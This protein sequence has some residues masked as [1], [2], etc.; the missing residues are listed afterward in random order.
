MAVESVRALV[1]AYAPELASV[2]D[3][4]ID[5]RCDVAEALTSARVFGAYYT[6]ALAYLTAHLLTVDLRA[7]GGPTGGGG[8]SAGVGPVTAERVGDLSTSYGSIGWT[9]RS[10]A[11]AD[12]S[13]TS[14]GI[15]WLA[16][17]DSRAGVLPVV[18]I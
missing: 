5:L 8:G 14:Y 17:R 1:R 9:P 16:L 6:I 10:A 11:D 13:A 7:S 4:A 3:S 12:L 18:V 15:R 2:S